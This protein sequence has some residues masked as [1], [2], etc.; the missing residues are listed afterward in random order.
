MRIKLAF[1]LGPLVSVPLVLLT[2]FVTHQRGDVMVIL[3]LSYIWCGL[4]GG[5]VYVSLRKF[6]RDNLV[7]C[8]LIGGA[9]GAL[10][11][12]VSVALPGFSVFS[13]EGARFAIL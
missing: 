9:A 12:L 3:G 4:I 1:L 2:D 10:C 8:M 5:V 6:G 13:I 7:L 11:F